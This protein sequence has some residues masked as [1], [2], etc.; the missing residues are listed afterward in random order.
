M[1]VPGVGDPDNVSGW[2]CEWDWVSVRHDGGMSEFAKRAPERVA[3]PLL[4]NRSKKGVVVFVDGHADFVARDYAH[5]PRHVL[6]R[7]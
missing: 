4:N 5:H 3:L 7:M 2:I 6:P 1:A